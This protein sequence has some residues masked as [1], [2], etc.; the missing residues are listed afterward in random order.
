MFVVVAP[1]I[2]SICNVHVRIHVLL[3]VT[4]CSGALD[5]CLSIRDT[6][7]CSYIMHILAY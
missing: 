7:I 1:H 5:V 6:L 3:Q 2:L 4:N